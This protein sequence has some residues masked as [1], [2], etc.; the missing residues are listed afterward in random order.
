MSPE[1]AQLQMTPEGPERFL[2]DPRRCQNDLEWLPNDAQMTFKWHA[3]YSQ[4]TPC[5]HDLQLTFTWLSNDPP[6]T[7]NDPHMTLTWPANHPHMT[8]IWLPYDPHMSPGPHGPR[9]LPL[10]LVLSSW[11]RHVL[12]PVWICMYWM[13]IWPRRGCILKTI[14]VVWDRC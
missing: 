14:L 3:H 1:Q 9:F 7:L 13:K 2:N 6:V 8:S 11:C 12:V 10:K 5:S 4:M